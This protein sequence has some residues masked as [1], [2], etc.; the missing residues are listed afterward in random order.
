MLIA[1]QLKA[2]ARRNKHASKKLLCLPPKIQYAFRNMR[3]DDSMGFERLCLFLCMQFMIAYTPMVADMCCVYC[4]LGRTSTYIG[5]SEHHRAA[6]LGSPL[7]RGVEH[8]FSIFF[9]RSG[10]AKN[11]NKMNAFKHETLADFSQFYLFSVPSDLAGLSE[12]ILIQATAANANT[13]HRRT[14]EFQTK[15]RRRPVKNKRE[16]H[17]R[18]VCNNSTFSGNKS[19]FYAE[20]PAQFQAKIPSNSLVNM[21]FRNAYFSI[22]NLMTGFGPISIFSH[23]V[24]LTVYLSKP[25]H[26]FDACDILRFVSVI[27]VFKS[28][29]LVRFIRS[30]L[31]RAIATSRLNVLLG[32]FGEVKIGRYIWHVPWPGTVADVKGILEKFWSIIGRGCRYRFRHIY[33]MVCIVQK[34]ATTYKTF[35]NMVSVARKMD[36][37]AFLQ[38]QLA[39]RQKAWSGEKFQQLKLYHK[40]RMPVDCGKVFQEL[41]VAAQQ[42]MSFAQTGPGFLDVILHELFSYCWRFC[43]A[44]SAD[45]FFGFLDCQHS[46]FVRPAVHQALV[47]EDKDPAAAWLMPLADY[48]RCLV[49]LLER[50]VDK[51]ELTSLSVRETWEF[52]RQC[53]QLIVDEGFGPKRNTHV[54]PD[55]LPYLYATVKAKCFISGHRTCVNP[56]HSCMRKIVSYA[57]LESSW[58]RLFR[59]ISRATMVLVMK[60]GFGDEVGSLALTAST[61]RR[62]FQDLVMPPQPLQN[63]KRCHVP[64]RP[65]ELLV[66]D[67]G[68]MYEAIDSQLV[69]ICLGFFIGL[70]KQLG[71]V[72]VAVFRTK[73]LHGYLARHNFHKHNNVDMMTFDQ[74]HAIHALSLKQ[75]F[76]TLGNLV[77]VQKRGVPIGGLLSKCQTSLVLCAEECAW[78]ANRMKQREFGCQEGLL[79]RNCVAACRYVDDC[80]IVSPYFCAD[81]LF[82]CLNA[83]SCVTYDRQNACSVTGTWLD[84]DMK[85]TERSLIIEMSKPET[86]WIARNSEQPKKFRIPP[87]VGT[88]VVDAKS[89]ILGTQARLQ[90]IYF[91]KGQILDQR[92]LSNSIHYVMNLWQRSGYADSYIRRTWCRY[93]SHPVLAKIAAAW[94]C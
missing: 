92:L 19:W 16:E 51:W 74:I 8:M 53:F 39:E 84:M 78:T 55:T 76:V 86:D 73:K 37:H 80:C 44:F 13:V 58:K 89:R 12:K 15:V 23:P 22:I 71:Y 66:A 3:K 48:C 4:L 14:S 91:E 35:F 1:F 56:L 65:L 82:R 75:K 33:S 36:G 27:A 21:S 79:W 10:D 42:F 59:R 77:Y 50:E 2:G 87:F 90:Q 49:H 6:I 83:R 29:Q 9:D 61:M 47:A 67:A 70:A 62:R 64:K 26:E 60:L 28:V 25:R 81:C 5:K 69:L 85:C 93:L 34:R 88:G 18:N 45:T 43:T 20:N 11:G 38:E 32:A 30:K 46:H 41:A 72:G 63:C 68:A 57:L 40:L 7:A 31:F 17:Y 94:T 54:Q 24:L 52:K